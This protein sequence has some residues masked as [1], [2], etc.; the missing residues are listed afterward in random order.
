MDRRG[1]GGARHRYVIM[2]GPMQLGCIK[3]QEGPIQE[4][5]VNG[6]MQEDLL[7]IVIDRLQGF[8]SG[9]FA[10]EENKNA[11]KAAE[12]ALSWLRH[13]TADRRTRGVEGISE[14]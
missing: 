10:C 2:A 12:Q 7:A 3:F 1:F 6:L 9:N 8:Q 4:N 13:R 5:G 14:K 11:L